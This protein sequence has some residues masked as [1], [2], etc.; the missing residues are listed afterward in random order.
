MRSF[1][2][3]FFPDFFLD[4]FSTFFLDF[5]PDFFPTCL[6]SKRKRLRHSVI[7]IWQRL[8][9]KERYTRIY[10]H[11]CSGFESHRYDISIEADLSIHWSSRDMVADRSLQ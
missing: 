9:L 2:P 5:F 6:R 4:F 7:I 8:S 3:D 1:F 11:V 10:P